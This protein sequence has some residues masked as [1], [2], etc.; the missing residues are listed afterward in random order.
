MIILGGG[1]SGI[2]TGVTGIKQN[3]GKKF[4]M[5]KEEEKGLIPCGIPYVLYDL[6]DVDKNAMGPTPFIEQAQ[7]K[8]ADDIRVGYGRDLI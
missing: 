2:I 6:N 7:Y 4:L 1:P 8:Y 3:P 5:L